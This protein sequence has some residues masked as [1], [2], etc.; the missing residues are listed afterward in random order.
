MN[1][2]GR[3]SRGLGSLLLVGLTLAVTAVI[4]GAVLLLTNHDPLQ[5]YGT[6][7]GGAFGS[8]TGLVGTL[9][10]ATPLM[11]TGLAAA[12]AFRMRVWNIGADGQLFMGAFGASWVALTFRHA[13]AAVLLP[14]VILGGFAGG[15]LWGLVPAVLRT[16]LGVN[17]I[18]SSL[19]LNYVAMLWVDFL[20]FGPWKDPSMGGWPYSPQFVHA[21]WLPAWGDTGVNLMLI[22]AILAAPA[23]RWVFQHTRW[24]YEVRV[25]GAETTAARYAGIARNVLA[26]M[27]LSGGLAGLAGAGQVAGVAHR[28]YELDSQGYGYTGIMVA[29]LG[30]LQPEVVVV[31]GFLF[32]ALLQGGVSLQMSGLPPSIVQMLQ[33]TVVLVALGCLTYARVRAGALRLPRRFWPARRM[34]AGG[35]AR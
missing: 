12:V 23:L 2:A 9:T 6:L 34:P 13:P 20:V 22:V 10:Y 24:G 19:M 29:W 1:V 32:G 4:G 33:G 31:V 11:L 17:E 35:A 21:A 8:Q 18:M 3:L 15:A 27:L 7:L 25:A 16:V 28:L 14:A 5:V 26:V 30:A